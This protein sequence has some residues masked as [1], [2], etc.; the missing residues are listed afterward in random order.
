MA[1][2]LHANFSLRKTTNYELSFFAVDFKVKSKQ[3]ASEEVAEAQ[4]TATLEKKFSLMVRE[5]LWQLVLLGLM[6]WVVVG[7]QDGNVYYQNRH[8]KNIFVTDMP[9]VFPATIDANILK[10]LEI[11]AARPCIIMFPPQRICGPLIHQE[12]PKADIFDWLKEV[13]VPNLYNTHNYNDAPLN[14]YANKFISDYY[15]IRLGPP[16]LRMLRVKPSN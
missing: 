9:T 10:S 2:V 14:A 1:R 7:N 11:Y 3:L 8:L 4:K 6:L 12:G 5:V 13:V 15:A 16:R